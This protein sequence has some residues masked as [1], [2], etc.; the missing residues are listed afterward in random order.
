MRQSSSSGIR[1]EFR[2][3]AWIDEAVGDFRYRFSDR[4]SKSNEKE[5]PEPAF[6]GAEPNLLKRPIN[7]QY[8]STL[9]IV[10]SG[11]MG[12]VELAEFMSPNSKRKPMS[13]PYGS[14]ANHHRPE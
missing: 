7:S 10:L 12:D 13:L 2:W 11:Q 14:P 6:S 5:V 8:R 1:Q 3:W 9:K 4:F